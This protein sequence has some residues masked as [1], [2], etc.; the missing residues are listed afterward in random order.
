M[1][2]EISH[3]W[4][5]FSGALDNF[6]HPHAD[7]CLENECKHEGYKWLII[8]G[9]DCSDTPYVTTGANNCITDARVLLH[10]VFSE[11]DAIVRFHSIWVEAMVCEFGEINCG[12]YRGGGHLDTGKLNIP[13]G[14]YIPLAWNHEPLAWLDEVAEAQPYRIHGE[15]GASPLDSWNTEGNQ[16]NYLSTD[17]EGDFR[18]RVGAGVHVRDGWGGVSPADPDILLDCPDFQCNQNNSEAALFRVWVTVPEALD[19]SQYDQDGLE[20][21]RFVGSGYTNRYGD[22]VQDCTEIGLD[23]IPFEST[24]VP[25]GRSRFRGELNNTNVDY[26]ISPFWPDGS[27]DWWIKY[28]N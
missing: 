3:P 15:P 23:C 17:P 27:R 13:R 1:G 12:I 25:L 18:L 20:N 11:Q 2:G 26:D 28:P 6:E 4:Q 10:M 7:S 21:G 22:I 5:T 16:Y 9:R 24:G 14:T 19:G 8:I